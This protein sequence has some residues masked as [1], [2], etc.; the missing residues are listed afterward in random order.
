MNMTYKR[1]PGLIIEDAYHEFF[2]QLST[3]IYRKEI[4]KSEL[5]RYLYKYHVDIYDEWLQ[6]YAEGES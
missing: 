5:D 1:D 2:D 3:A 6:W 4:S